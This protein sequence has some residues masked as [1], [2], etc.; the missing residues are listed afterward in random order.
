MGLNTV[1][2][3]QDAKSLPLGRVISGSLMIAG[4]TIGAGMLGIP[5]ETAKAGF[6]PS[7][8][9]TIL[10]WFFMLCTGLLFMEVS[11]WMPEG[12]NVLSMANRFLGQTGRNLAGGLFVFLYYCLMVAYFAAGAPLLD[13]FFSGGLGMEMQGWISYLIFG[14][15]FWLIVGFGAKW[16]DK[17]NIIL[18]VAM[19]IS[20]LALI[21]T[22]S[23]EI[24][25]R[26]LYAAHWPSMFYAIPILFSA[27][28]YHNMIPSLSTHLDRNKKALRI[29]II[30]G[31]GIALGVYLVWQWIFIGSI[32]QEMILEAQNLGLPATQALQSVTGKPWIYLIGKYFAFFAIVTSL[33][34]VAFSMV[35]FLAD[36][37]KISTKGSKQMFLS[38]LTFSP[39]FIFAGINPIFF[40]K[41][42]GIAGG[43]GEAVLNGLFP[44]GLVWMGRYALNLKTESAILGKKWVL[45]LLFA[46]SVCVMALEAVILMTQ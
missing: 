9:M 29:S 16:V 5:L 11:L 41:A 17:T 25:P 22:G 45:I 15:I 44:V 33:L 14:V 31:T 38:F 8:V 21:G 24:Q 30:S 40:D 1:T 12:T 10:V 6:F 26:Y 34:G 35:D 32:P 36:G 39:P 2:L 37:L 27:F 7:I 46:I 42:L 20:Y 43:F 3:N 19:V 18:T 28:G 13:G 23:S 4:T